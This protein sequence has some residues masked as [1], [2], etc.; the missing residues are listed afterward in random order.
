MALGP[1][2]LWWVLDSPGIPGSVSSA[3]DFLGKSWC[4]V[5]HL[6]RSLFKIVVVDH[7][8]SDQWLTPLSSN[9]L[10][11]RDWPLGIK[12]QGCDRPGKS[13]TCNQRYNFWI[14][15]RWN[16]SIG[17][18]AGQNF[19]RHYKYLSFTIYI[20]EH[21]PYAQMIYQPI[22]NGP[23]Q[24]MSCLYTKIKLQIFC[25]NCFHNKCQFKSEVTRFGK[26]SRLIPSRV[27][28]Y[29]LNPR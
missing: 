20:S 13:S 11:G 4:R 10:C 1:K 12:P 26:Y 18:N 14:T 25:K 3:N 2:V 28:G 5:S 29:R 19:W 16:M 27:E 17:I 8:P 9:C 23:Q 7:T 22:S 24:E 15:W 21:I 6:L